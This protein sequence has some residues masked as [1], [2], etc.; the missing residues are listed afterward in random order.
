AGE[1]VNS[2]VLAKMKLWSRGQ[3]L[4]ARTIGSTILGQGID[5]L[6]FYPVAF[7]GLW[8]NEQLL[9]VMATNWALKVAW[10]A[11]LTPVTYGVVG[12]LK[13]R[14]GIDLYDEGTDFSPFKGKGKSVFE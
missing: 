14:E 11:A 12:W 13:A 3:M 4:W 5:S 6:I 1:F 9:T 2:Y 8:S 7:W 10:E